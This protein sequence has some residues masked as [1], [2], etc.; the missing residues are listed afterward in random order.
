MVNSSGEHNN[1]II[2]LASNRNLKHMNHL[3]EPIRFSNLKGEIIH[4][5]TLKIID[6]THKEKISKDIKYVKNIINQYF[7]MNFFRM[8]NSTIT[9]YTFFSSAYKTFHKIDSSLGHRITIFKRI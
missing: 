4:N 8:L 1:L 2:H 7:L 9:G 5:T 3:L 6:R